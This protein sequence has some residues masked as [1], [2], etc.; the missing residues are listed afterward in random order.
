M[1]TQPELSIIIVNW[2]S[3]EYLWRC[4]GSLF[5]ANCDCNFEV[6]VVDNGSYDG[7][8]EM[9]SEHFPQVRFLQ[10]PKNLGFA[11]ANNLAF[12]FSAGRNLLFLNPDTEVVGQG[13][14]RMLD[15]LAATPDAGLVGP[16]LVAPDFSTQWNCMRR[17]PTILNQLLDASLT[18]RIFPSWWGFDVVACEA[19]EPLAAEVVPGTCLLV[20]RDVFARAGRFNQAYFMYVE[21]VDLCCRARKLGW[22]TYYLHDAVVIHHGGRSSRMQPQSAFSAVLMRESVVKFLSLNRGRACA[23]L[24]RATTGLAAICRLLLCGGLLLTARH[25]RRPRWRVAA[26]KWSGVLRWSLGL[27]PWARALSAAQPVPPTEFPQ[28]I[29]TGQ[30]LRA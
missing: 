12:A 26:H 15:A 27:E 14:R 7:C 6:L 5:S 24:Y 11:A 3:A 22:K 2:N 4:L 29:S 17:A 16:R 8:G 20:R 18:R 23:S 30:R 13:L 19:H 10:L 9:L 1:T 21:D 25:E 28:T